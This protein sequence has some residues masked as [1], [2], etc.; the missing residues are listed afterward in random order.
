MPN[1]F[2]NSTGYEHSYEPNTNDLVHAMDYNHLGQ[3]IVR[4]VTGFGDSANF[5]AFSRMRVAGTRLLG[6]F[7][8]QYGTM[9]PVE[10]LTHFENGGDQTV[11]LSRTH[12]LINV[13]TES[14]SRAVRQSRKYH[15]YIPGTTNLAF[16]SFT[17]SEAK[18]NLQQMVGLFDDQ[19]G[20]FFRMNGTVAEMVIRKGGVDNEVIPQSN[21]NV[22]RLDGTGA[23]KLHLDFTKSQIF[24]CDYQWLGVGRVRVGFNLDGRIYYAHYF[25][26]ANNIVEPYSFQ[27]SLPVRYE[28]RNSGATASASSMMCICYSVYC[29]G[30]DADTG[31]DNSV[32]NGASSVSLGSGADSVKGILAVRLKNTVNG[33]PNRAHAILKDW[34]VLTTLTAQYKVMILQGI[35]DIAGTPVWTDATPTGWCEYTTNFSLAAPPTPARAVILYDGYAAGSNN[36]GNQS[37]AQTDNRSAAIHQNFDSTDSMIFAVVGYRIPNDNAVMRASLNWTEI[38]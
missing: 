6:E 23:S 30:N 10:I 37:T 28:I 12:T 24:V 38:K 27:P 13:T 11:D 2:P 29:E 4:T 15:P 34:E 9:G 25:S 21:W 5:S 31:F 20:I 16:V 19:N 1:L 3:P 32:S 33:Q 7:R 17:L 35:A 22:D 8:N 26:H 18:T 36:K 14:G